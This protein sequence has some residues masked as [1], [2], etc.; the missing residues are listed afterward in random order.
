MRINIL[1]CDTFPGLLPP[2]IPSY[3]S[4]FT[5]LFDAVE[6][7]LDYQ[8][9]RAMNGEF[10]NEI[11]PDELYLITGCNLS[12]YDDVA[13]IRQLLA[14][15]RYARLAQ[16]RIAGICF[17]HQAIAYALGGMVQR[18]AAGWGC[19]LRRSVVLASDL[20]S[21]LGSQ[22]LRLLYNHHDQVIVPPP[23]A[24]ILATSDFCP[25]EAM[26]VGSRILSFQGHPEYTTAYMRHLLEH[27][28][29]G[30]APDVVAAAL[31]S[32]R[33]PHMGHDIARYILQTLT[34]GNTA[35]P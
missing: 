23:E 7:G 34:G 33:Q 3:F 30:E 13:W 2:D 19:G 26:R 25:A 14:W 15:I 4:M 22:A 9:Y 10:P 20:R 27:H 18:A 16:G 31:A 1:L 11:R 24:E 32:L 21:A 29:E 17:G 6:N 35:N 12:V 5:D 28:S 8:E